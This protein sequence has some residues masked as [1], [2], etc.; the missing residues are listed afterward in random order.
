MT[1][2]KLLLTIAGGLGVLGAILPW[3]RVSIFGVSVSSTAFQM[4]ALYVILAILAILAGV[5]L[6]LL[7]VLNEKQIKG[8]IK[9]KKIDSLPLY[10][11]IALAAIAVI[12]FIAVKVESSGLGGTSFGVWLIALAGVAGVVLPLLK[13]IEHLDKTVIGQPAKKPAAKKEAAKKEE[14]KK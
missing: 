1:L 10:V 7:N 12:A 9:L 4:G 13:G 3:Y 8:F 5:A 6:I 14:T 2:K 11:G